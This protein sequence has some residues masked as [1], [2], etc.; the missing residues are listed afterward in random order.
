M[1]SDLPVKAEV[2][3]LSLWGYFHYKRGADAG[4]DRA[5]NEGVHSNY[6]KSV[7]GQGLFDL[8]PSRFTLMWIKIKFPPS[9][10][11]LRNSESCKSPTRYFF[12]LA[13]DLQGVDLHSHYACKG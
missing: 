13:S 10:K 12:Q 9:G 7:W 2:N 8:C 6:T 11:S 1:Q 3:R 5:K 4:F